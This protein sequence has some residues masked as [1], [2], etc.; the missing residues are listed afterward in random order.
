MKTSRILAA[1]AALAMGLAACGSDDGGGDEAAGT[2]TLSEYDLSGVSYTVGS[3]DFDEQLVLGYLA[4]EALQEAGADVTDQ[5]GLAGTAAAREALL[6]GEIDM[7]WEYNGTG[8][9]IHLG[10]DLDPATLPENLTEE[11]ATADLDQN[12][13]Q[14]LDAAG[15]NNTYAFAVRADAYEELGATNITEMTQ[16]PIEDQTLCVESEFATRED[17][18]PGL[19]AFIGYDFPE[20]TIVDTG[21]VYTQTAAGECNYGEVF[22]S[23]GRIAALDLVVLEDDLNFFPPYDPSV[24]IREEKFAE[25]EAVADVFA[26]LGEALD[27]ETMQALNARVSADGEFPEDVARDFLVE[28][29]LISG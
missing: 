23:D 6:A 15:F 8:W 27:L 11:V 19:E 25:N 21:V 10:N 29:G 18:L 24:N 9:G 26:E 5:I 3:K 22:A 28:Q 7:Y 14:W 17:G 16:L 2:G 1:T 13:I 12:G 20:P 4:I